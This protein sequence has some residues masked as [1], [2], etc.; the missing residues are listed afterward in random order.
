MTRDNRYFLEIDPEI[1]GKDALAIRKHTSKV[2][3][4]IASVKFKRGILDELPFEVDKID[5]VLSLVNKLED[6]IEK[7]SR[8]NND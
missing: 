6:G 5:F 4:G 8:S 1:V 2:D 3:S 7:L